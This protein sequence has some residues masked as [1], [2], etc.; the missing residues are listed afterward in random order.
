MKIQGKIVDETNQPIEGVIIGS[1]AF[2][3]VFTTTDSDGKFTLENDKITSISPIKI[4]YIGYK[5]EFPIAKNL[6]GKTLQ[7]KESTNVLDAVTVFSGS[8]T[9]QSTKTEVPINFLQKYKTPITVVSIIVVIVAGTL[10]IKK[11][12]K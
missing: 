7:L 9:E 3:D 6:N 5:E 12:L 10:L 4:S 1:A 2:K 8:K 11:A